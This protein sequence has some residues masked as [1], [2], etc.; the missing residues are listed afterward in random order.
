M[1]RR[2]PIFKA[3]GAHALALLAV[4]VAVVFVGQG[5]GL[6]PPLWSAVLLQ[7]VLATVF[8]R[9]FG[10]ARGWLVFRP[11]SCRLPSAC[12]RSRCRPGCIWLVF[13]WFCCSTGTAS[14]TGFRSI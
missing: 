12:M 3:L 9:R 10:L 6:R 4:A 1:R 14:G 2:Y 11:D 13:F 5:L 8:G 7:A